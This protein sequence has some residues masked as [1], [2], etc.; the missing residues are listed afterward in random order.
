MKDPQDW[1]DEQIS[2][3][4]AGPRQQREAA[5]RV[6][7]RSLA[8]CSAVLERVKT[9]VTAFA[10]ARGWRLEF[11]DGAAPRVGYV[12]LL[13]DLRCPCCPKHRLRGIYP[14]PDRLTDEE[15]AD[16]VTDW[17]RVAINHHIERTRQ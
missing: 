10:E 7:P 6:L 16:L 11:M 9:R 8:S 17:F 4:Y 5:R 12:T 2:A 14:I 13:G 3:L 15:A 1:I